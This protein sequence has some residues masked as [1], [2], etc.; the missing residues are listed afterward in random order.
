[1]KIFVCEFITGGGFHDQELPEG[2][3]REGDMMLEVLLDDLLDAGVDKITI[4]R[5]VRLPDINKPVRTIPSTSNIWQQWQKIMA[6]IECVIIIA[7]E[8]DNTLYNLTKI[9]D[10]SGCNLIGCTAEAIKITSS[11]LRTFELLTKHEIPCIPTWRYSKEL[12]HQENGWVIKPDDGVGGVGCNYFD[13][14]NE[15]ET[16]I[17][18]LPIEQPQ[19]IQPYL[20]GVS[21]SLS[22]LCCDG[23]AKVIGCHKQLFEFNQGKGRLKGII[24]NGLHEHLTEFSGL[25][26]KIATA[27][28]GLW[29]Y[30]GV[31]FILT[32]TGP[33]LLEINPR[34]TTSYVGLHKSLQQNPV[35]WMLS[36]KQDGRLPDLHAVKYSPVQ[37]T[38]D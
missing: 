25:A 35:E 23:Q 11:K 2:L 17:N 30:V 16:Y 26:N 12:A 37:I 4:T 36:M 15:L 32:K 21:G 6:G 34:L 31:D 8:N 9:A 33:R 28:P 14:L 7:P 24:V 29:G 19:V 18:G 20:S 5:D 10:Q 13:Q 1:V 3:A 27:I 22:L 38:L